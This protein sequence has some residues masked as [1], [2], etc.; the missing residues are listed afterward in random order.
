MA[1]KANAFK[2][3]INPDDEIFVSSGNMPKRIKEY[4]KEKFG[5]MPENI[6]EIAR[7]INESLAF[8]YKAS[9]KEIEECT[10]KKYE[11]IYMI[12]GGIQSEMLCQMT[13]N[14]CGCTVF[15]GPIEATV[16]GNIAIQL[17]ANGKIKNLKEARKIIKNSEKIKI[18]EPKDI[19]IWQENYKKFEKLL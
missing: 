9:L 5:Q 19:E 1:T 18:Y 11:K 10:G 6:G 17:I 12:G 8:K 4:C 15:A 14:A 13:A 16:F 7:A 3:F 2:Y